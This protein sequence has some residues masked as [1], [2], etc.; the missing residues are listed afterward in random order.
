MTYLEKNLKKYLWIYYRVFSNSFFQNIYVTMVFQGLWILT[1][2]CSDIYKV[3]SLVLFQWKQKCWP[4]HHHNISLKAQKI[5]FSFSWLA[6]FWSHGFLS[7]SSF[8][9]CHLENLFY[10]HKCNTSAIDRKLRKIQILKTDWASGTPLFL[11]FPT[12]TLK[13]WSLHEGKYLHIR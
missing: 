7:F 10:W 5:F 13:Y 11:I 8:R 4:E 3:G 6:F 1:I 2:Y 12:L 9:C